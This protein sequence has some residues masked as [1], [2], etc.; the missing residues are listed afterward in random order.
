MQPSL[1]L[2]YEAR[3]RVSD[4]VCHLRYEFIRLL[5]CLE[6][7]RDLFVAAGEILQFRHIVRIG[8]E[9]CIED[10]VAV[11]RHAVLEAEALD[12]HRHAVAVICGEHLVQDL[13]ELGGSKERRV[14]YA[15]R[16]RPYVLEPLALLSY[17]LGKRGIRRERVLAPR[18]LVSAD[19][20]IV[21][22]LKEY[23]LIRTADILFYPFESI[24]KT[25]EEFL[26][27]DVYDERQLL[28]AELL[29]TG[30]LNKARYYIGQDIRGHVVHAEIPSVL[31]IINGTALARS[32]H[33]GHKNDF[34][35]L[36][37]FSPVRIFLLILLR[38]LS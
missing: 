27:P 7:I 4:K 13:L 3:D 35:D 9:P 17:R 5:E 36:T 2:S 1:A 10:I 16:H 38:A 18:L 26:R 11:Y 23:D 19:K 31:K 34:H 30:A 20:D 15:R 8:N 14:Y 28:Y 24:F 12:E 22:C 29:G 33:S 37:P 21:G 25:V 32:A 6:I